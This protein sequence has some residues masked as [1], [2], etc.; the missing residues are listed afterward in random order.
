MSA[1]LSASDS[2]VTVDALLIV[3]GI[4]GLLAIET[5]TRT[6]T[7]IDTTEQTE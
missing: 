3:G 5:D 7:V 6:A 2:I 1:D 4:A